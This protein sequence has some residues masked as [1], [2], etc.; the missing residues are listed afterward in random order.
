M[1]SK[2]AGAVALSAVA[3]VVLVSGCAGVNSQL[4][5][6]SGQSSIS[7]QNQADTQRREMAE[8]RARQHATPLDASKLSAN[9]AIRSDKQAAAKAAGLT[10]QAEAYRAQVEQHALEQ[11]AA[12]ELRAQHPEQTTPPSDG[13]QDTVTDE[14]RAAQHPQQEQR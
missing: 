3:L 14:E 2:K 8:V 11:V 6:G 12:E 10:K 1:N 4:D 7:Q 13:A 9:E 5:A